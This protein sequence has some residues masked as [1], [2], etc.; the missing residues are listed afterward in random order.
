MVTEHIYTS[1]CEKGWTLTSAPHCRE[2]FAYYIVHCPVNIFHHILHQSCARSQPHQTNYTSHDR[3]LHCLLCTTK[4]LLQLCLHQTA[5]LFH[6]HHVQYNRPSS[7]LICA[8]LVPEDLLEVFLRQRDSEP[9]SGDSK[10][11]PLRESLSFSGAVWG[12]STFVQVRGRF[13]RRSLQNKK[14]IER[15]L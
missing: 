6:Y 7:R 5:N 3:R 9:R 4:A 15:Q 11:S 2:H 12:Q 1:H 10:L 8:T 14:K 13:W